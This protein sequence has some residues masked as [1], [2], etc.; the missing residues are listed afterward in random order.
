MINITNIDYNFNNENNQPV[1]KPAI[2][3]NADSKFN[4]APKETYFKVMKRFSA[5]DGLGHDLTQCDNYEQAMTEAD[6][7]YTG[8]KKP[9]YL[10]N[11]NVIPD[12]FAVV[13][14]DDENAVLGIVGNQYQ[15]I[16][17]M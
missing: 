3:L 16:G 7:N 5:F 1:E 11:G 10:G 8:E 14:S 6:L 4:N 2:H 9:I 15:T 12:N 17:N 13:K